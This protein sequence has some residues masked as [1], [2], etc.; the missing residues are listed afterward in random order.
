MM[1]HHAMPEKRMG[2][3]QMKMEQM[4]QHSQAMQPMPAKWSRY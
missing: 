2:M 1:Q 3:M 4:M